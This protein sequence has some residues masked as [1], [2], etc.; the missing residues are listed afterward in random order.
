MN[1]FGQ[2]QK[3][4]LADLLRSG[5]RFTPQEISVLMT[6]AARSLAVRHKN[7]YIHGHICPETI[8]IRDCSNLYFCCPLPKDYQNFLIK[9]AAFSKTDI[10]RTA[11]LTDDADLAISEKAAGP[12]RA[13]ESYIGSDYMTPA[14]DVYSLCCVMYRAVTGSVPVSA[15]DR[16]CG[17]TL[18]WPSSS[19][20]LSSNG[21]FRR[22]LEKGLALL[23]T[24][25][26]ADAGQ[27]LESLAQLRPTAPASSSR[28]AAVKN[29]PC[30]AY[31]FL[32]VL[33]PQ[34]KKM[35]SFYIGRETIASITFFGTKIH[36]APSRVFDVSADRSGRIIAWASGTNHDL[37][38]FVAGDGGVAA[39][40]DCRDMFSGCLNLQSIHFNHALD[41]AN[42]I[43]M[44]RMFCNTPMLTS[45][46]LTDFRTD[47][48][49][50]MSEMFRMCG[51]HHLNLSHF[52][53]SKVR[54]MS[55][56]F[57]QST[58]YDIDVSSFDTSK[59]TDMS[60]MFF[61]CFNIKSLDLSHFDTSS[62]TDMAYMFRNCQNLNKLDISHFNTSKVKDMS[63]MFSGCKNLSENTQTAIRGLDMSHV[64]K[65]EF[66]FENSP[67]KEAAPA[68]KPAASSETYSLF[69]QPVSASFNRSDNRPASASALIRIRQLCRDFASTHS[70]HFK[71][72]I[73]VKFRRNMGLPESTP[74][75]LSHDNSFLQSGKTGFAVT[76][77]GFYCKDFGSSPAVFTSFQEVKKLKKIYSRDNYIYADNNHRLVYASI[78]ARE[79]TDLENLIREIKSIL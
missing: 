60:Y 14:A 64:L 21:C 22:I 66:M 54:N 42:V 70:G 47:N 19:A 15:P 20:A 9:N 72:D 17:K 40:K 12:Y 57:Y 74:V 65:K 25:R 48:V 18:V 77:R 39:N 7:G 51:T 2:I 49:T 29:A 26:Y 78:P 16:M 35:Y 44:S 63:F 8:V 28:P 34:L 3:Q 37:K 61:H 75:Y 11:A 67:L 73:S 50:T 30:L 46:D 32:S 68:P 62:V 43:S 31:D 27:L 56:M 10:S 79:Q 24:D 53:T 13:L 6:S 59:A 38:I 5:H 58:S 23:P 69:N 33:M 55:G 41:T 4:S 1:T 71:S 45:L 36:H 76:D 52:N